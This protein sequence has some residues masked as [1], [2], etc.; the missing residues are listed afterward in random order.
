V[1]LCDRLISPALRRIGDAWARERISLAEEHRASAICT[2]LLA[3]IST[4]PRGRPRGIAVVTTVPGEAHELPGMMAAM[5]LRAERWQVHHLGAQVPYD[6]LA[7]LVE[8][9]AATLVVL[10]VTLTAALPE[11]RRYA[12][13]IERGIG[14]PTVVGCPGASLAELR[15]L[16]RAVTS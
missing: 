13:L 1:E 3:R 6:Q 9:E 2:R 14:V 10:S 4:Q 5:A 11:S 8:R 16:A 15:D 7:G 12:G